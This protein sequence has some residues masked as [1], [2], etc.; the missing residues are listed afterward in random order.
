MIRIKSIPKYKFRA[1]TVVSGIENSTHCFGSELMWF[2]KPRAEYSSIVVLQLSENSHCTLSTQRVFNDVAWSHCQGL[3]F[4]RGTLVNSGKALRVQRTPV[5]ILLEK[6]E[7]N[8]SITVKKLGT[9][10]TTVPKRL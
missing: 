4:E 9:R 1:S 6:R 10:H 3:Y 7:K 2:W 5:S 8:G